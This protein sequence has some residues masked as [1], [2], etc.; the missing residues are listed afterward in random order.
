MDIGNSRVYIAGRRYIGAPNS[1][2]FA[3]CSS[4]VI[5]RRQYFK[6][7]TPTLAGLPNPEFMVADAV[8]KAADWAVLFF[9]IA[10]S[11]RSRK[12]SF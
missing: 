7:L 12:I 8:A 2:T 9:A 10:A 4:K 6:Q 1:A 3:N 5:A 11:G